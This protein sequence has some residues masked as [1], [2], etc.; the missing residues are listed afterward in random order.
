VRTLQR[1]HIVIAAGQIVLVIVE[2]Q[3]DLFAGAVAG[4]IIPFFKRRGQSAINAPDAALPRKLP[5]PADMNSVLRKL[6]NID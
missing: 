4:G 3:V 2:L 5:V 6:D 1:K